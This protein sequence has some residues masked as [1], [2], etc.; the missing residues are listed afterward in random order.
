MATTDGAEIVGPQYV[1]MK[2]FFASFILITATLRRWASMSHFYLRTT[3]CPRIKEEHTCYSQQLLW[4]VSAYPLLRMPC[5]KLTKPSVDECRSF[6]VV[7]PLLQS[8]N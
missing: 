4:S 5:C 6:S 8:C 3:Q 2:P 7:L 1:S